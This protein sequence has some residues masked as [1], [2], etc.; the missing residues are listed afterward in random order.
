MSFSPD[1]EDIFEVVYESKPIGLRLS[2]NR[3]RRVPVVFGFESIAS[4]FHGRVRIGDEIIS[5]N[6]NCL[7]EMKFKDSAY[8]LWTLSLPICMKLRRPRAITSF[9]ENMDTLSSVTPTT[10]TTN[11]LHQTD[12]SKPTVGTEEEKDSE[13]FTIKDSESGK[14]MDHAAAIETALI[15]LKSRMNIKT[16]SIETLGVHRVPILRTSLLHIMSDI[17]LTVTRLEKLEKQMDTIESYNENKETEKDRE[18]KRR[19]D[20]SESHTVG[21]TVSCMPCPAEG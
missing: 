7:E 2:Y 9:C 5:A 18:T 10:T 4:S 3:E 19:T 1:P 17:T 11:T 16:P 21:T 12:E 6:D 14:S 8:I 13:V 15:K 20:I